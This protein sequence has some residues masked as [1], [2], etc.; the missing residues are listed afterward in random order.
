MKIVFLIYLDGTYTNGTISQKIII[1]NA[2]R[3]VRI[4]R[5]KLYSRKIKGKNLKHMNIPVCRGW[6]LM[7]EHE[8]RNQL[9]I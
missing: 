7:Y 2:V 4:P 8:V 1:P 9:P 5:T 6:L 3:A